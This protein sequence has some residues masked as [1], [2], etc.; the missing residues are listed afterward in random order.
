MPLN[1]T[2]EVLHLT[3]HLQALKWN[4]NEINS[5]HSIAYPLECTHD[6]LL[7]PRPCPCIHN[8]DG[9]YLIQWMKVDFMWVVITSLKGVH[10]CILMS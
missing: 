1:F 3:A 7:S 6:I 9:K 4:S 5:Y 2:N 10:T 8:I